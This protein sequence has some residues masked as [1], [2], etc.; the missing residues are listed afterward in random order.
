V[1]PVDRQTLARKLEYLRKQLEQLEPYRALSQE[2]IFSE[3]EKRYTV[4]RLLELSIQSVIDCGRL[5]VSLE[6]WRK[7]RDERDAFLILVE[8]KVIDEDLAERLLRAKG[9][10]NILV[11][12]YVDIDPTLLFSHLRSGVEDLW[13]FAQQL[14]EYLH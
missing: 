14:A 4:E 9:F 7:L 13:V 6:D 5:L 11:H 10:R 12:E 1:N 2:E 8:R 3:I